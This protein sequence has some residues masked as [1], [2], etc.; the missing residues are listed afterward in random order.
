MYIVADEQ[1]V[2][3]LIGLFISRNTFIKLQ[4]Y[5]SLI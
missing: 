5:D 3:R 1:T 4:F 2:L